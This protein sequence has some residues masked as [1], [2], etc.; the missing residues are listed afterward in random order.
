MR[1]MCSS[2]MIAPT[3]VVEKRSRTVRVETWKAWLLYSECEDIVNAKILAGFMRHIETAGGKVLLAAGGV[4][5]AQRQGMETHQPIEVH[6]L[7]L[8]KFFLV[9]ILLTHLHN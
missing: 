9:N 6:S 3:S 7:I 8:A 4:E 1:W 2:H 5:E